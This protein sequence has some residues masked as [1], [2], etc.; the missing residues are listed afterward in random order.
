MNVFLTFECLPITFEDLKSIY[1]YTKLLNFATTSDNAC[2]SMQKKNFF[3][4][5]S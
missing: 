3:T 4:M 1:Y 5:K 2:T